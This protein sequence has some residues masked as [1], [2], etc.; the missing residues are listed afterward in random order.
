MTEMFSEKSNKASER[1]H[2][3][4]ATLDEA[5]QLM[6]TIAGNGH[7]GESLKAVFRRLGRKL[8]NWSANRIRDVWY[9]DPRVVVRANEVAQLRALA[10]QRENRRSTDDELRELR[11]TVARLAKYEAL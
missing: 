3:M 9:R 2:S 4:N 1:H 7:A 5:A 8:T 11:A 6:R 10:G